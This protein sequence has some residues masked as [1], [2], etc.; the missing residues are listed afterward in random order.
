MVEK[1]IHILQLFWTFAPSDLSQPLQILT[2]KL[3]IDILTRGY[4]FLWT[5]PWVSKKSEW[6]W[7]CCE[8]DAIF[9]VRGNWLIPPRW[10]LFI[11]RFIIIHPISSPLIIL[12]MNLG[13]SLACCLSSCRQKSEGLLAVAQESRHKSRRIAAH[14]QI[15]CHSTLNGPLWQPYCFTNM[16]DSLPT[17]CKNRLENL[18]F[19]GVVLVSGFP[20][21]SPSSIDVRPSLKRLNH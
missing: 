14:V 5:M 13:S 7:Y 19:S 4:K 9:S 10:M 20:Q 15:F 17:N 12:D 3:A 21:R 2:I 6:T 8:I 1:R 16:M 18:L 11:L